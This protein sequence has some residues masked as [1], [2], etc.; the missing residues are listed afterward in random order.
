MNLET[1]VTEFLGAYLGVDEQLITA[2]LLGLAESHTQLCSALLLDKLTVQS[3]MVILR[4]C[5]IPKMMYSIRTSAPSLSSQ[6]C[7]AFDRMVL[8]VAQKKLNLPPLDR[9]TVL[10]L[11]LPL[12]QRGFGLA[13]S[14]LNAPAAYLSSVASASP[15]IL[16]G[17]GNPESKVNPVL[18][19][20][21]AQTEQEMVIS[22][23]TSI[24]M[25]QH[26]QQALKSLSSLLF[27]DP[28]PTLPLRARE[29]GRRTLARCLCLEKGY[30]RFTRGCSIL[31][32]LCS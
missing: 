25:A 18:I 7:Q 19:P 17:L 4:Q 8:T 10:Q 6:A 1:G 16:N 9:G 21:D 11:H 30:R 31:T 5:V 3:A 15:Y 22:K 29:F 2:R 23:R 14:T 20:V 24:K 12:T 32:V 27:S 13:L 28:P 26:V